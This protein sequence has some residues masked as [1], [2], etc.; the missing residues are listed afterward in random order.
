MSDYARQA[1]ENKMKEDRKRLRESKRQATM[2]LARR[3]GITV[4][5]LRLASVGENDIF[6]SRRFDRE[7]G[8]AGWL[9][10]GFLSALSFMQWDEHDRY[11]W[12]YAAI[13]DV[14]RR[15]M[16]AE[17]IHELYRRMVFNVLVGNTDN[18]PRNH[19]F[20]VDDG[21]MFLSPAYDIVP[22][23]ARIGAGTGFGLA[24]SVGERGRDATLENALSRSPRYGL[25]KEDALTIVQQLVEIVS[26][27]RE[28]FKECGVSRRHVEFLA[29]SFAICDRERA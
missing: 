3:C 5:E 9:K 4:P 15:Y 22:T 26:G 14:M 29:P 25:S 1:V 23:P 17:D 13:A 16:T 28:H 20:L 2:E 24:M 18:H 12:D 6:L 19:G 21:K 27:W 7:K 11:L 8:R 10:R